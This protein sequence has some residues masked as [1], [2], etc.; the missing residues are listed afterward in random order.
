MQTH[1][2][3]IHPLK[4]KPPSDVACEYTALVRMLAG[5]QSRVTT[6]VCDHQQQIQALQAQIMRLRARVVVQATLLAWLRDSLVQLEPEP[7][8]DLTAHAAAADWVI[9]QTGCV[10]HGGYW[11]EDDGC[12]RTGK[13]CVLVEGSEGLVI[14]PP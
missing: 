1:P 13:G 14:Q 2:V 3:R 6:L 9:C 7:P 4:A 8:E 11:R 10:S 12:R 5:A